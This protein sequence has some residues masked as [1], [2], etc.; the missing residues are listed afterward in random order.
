[1]TAS[2]A[3]LVATQAAQPSGAQVRAGY[4]VSLTDLSGFQQALHQAQAGGGTAVL[5]PNQGVNASSRVAQALFKP[6]EHVNAE[7][8]S[9]HE[10]AQSVLASGTDLTPGEMVMLTVRAQQFL[11]HSQL[12][13]NIANRSSDGLQQLFRQQA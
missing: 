12:T 11:F 7:A 9:L 8:A 4:N 13:S 10:T 6:L 5:A 2:A 1:M 3:S